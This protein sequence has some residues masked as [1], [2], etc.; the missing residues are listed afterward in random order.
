MLP[1]STE[2]VAFGDERMLQAPLLTAVKRDLPLL[3]IMDSI[4]DG[5]SQD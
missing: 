5:V 3:S 4:A 2:E 1:T